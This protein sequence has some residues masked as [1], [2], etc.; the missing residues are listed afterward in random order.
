MPKNLDDC[1]LRARERPQTQDHQ[2]ARRRHAIILR[3]AA[4]QPEECERGCQRRE[5]ADDNH[6]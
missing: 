4:Q 5:R 2:R 6:H 3:D 1:S